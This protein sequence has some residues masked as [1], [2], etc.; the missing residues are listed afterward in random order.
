MPLFR[1]APLLLVVCGMSVPTAAGQRYPYG[2]AYPAQALTVTYAPV[3]FDFDGTPRLDPDVAA[4]SRFDYDGPAYGLTYT[5]PGFQ[6]GVLYGQAPRAY[7]APG[8]EAP[9]L[10]LLDVSLLTYAEA[11]RLVGDEEGARRLFVPLGLVSTYRRV[12]RADDAAGENLIDAFSVTVLGIGSGLGAFVAA[13]ERAQFAAR[14]MPA[15]G[16]AS[17]SLGDSNGS[18]RLLDADATLYLVEL[19]GRF[20]LSVGYTFRFQRWNLGLSDLLNL[21]DDAFDYVGR[22]HAL[23]LGLTW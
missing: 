17:R 8:G 23:R 21:D 22:Q 14:V 13:G 16:F 4:G 7:T 20:G 3:A 19:A 9:D 2:G 6:V 12:A 11:L 1:L 18:S 15:L 5:R 10:R